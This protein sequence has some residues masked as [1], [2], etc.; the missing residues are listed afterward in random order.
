MCPKFGGDTTV[1]VT[2]Q[3]ENAS[4]VILSVVIS[5]PPSSEQRGQG[6]AFDSVAIVIPCNG[7]QQTVSL[8]PDAIRGPGLAGEALLLV[9]NEGIEGT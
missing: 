1:T 3:S 7:T 8:F 6:G 2:Y 9:V 5:D 4:R